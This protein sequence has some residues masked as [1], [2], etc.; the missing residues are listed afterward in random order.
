MSKW[1]R[2]SFFILFIWKTGDALN[3]SCVRENVHTNTDTKLSCEGDLTCEK[4]GEV[5]LSWISNKARKACVKR[6]IAVRSALLLFAT[7]RNR[8]K[9]YFLVLC[10][11]SYWQRSFLVR[12][13]NKTHHHH[14]TKY[15]NQQGRQG[16]NS[17]EALKF[18]CLLLLTELCEWASFNSTTF[19]S[20]LSLEDRWTKT[21]ISYVPFTSK[22]DRWTEGKSYPE[23]LLA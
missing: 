1:L 13:T 5:K 4:L 2:N 8:Y 3:F 23:S 19:A 9:V 7:I 21:I 16:F 17:Y 10:F 15:P 12:T 14:H 20:R 11:C 6:V 22:A 18:P